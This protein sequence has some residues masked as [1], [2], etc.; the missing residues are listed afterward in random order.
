MMSSRCITP[1][2]GDRQPGPPLAEAA[3]H[4]Q[5]ETE[6]DRRPRRTACR[7]G[8]K[9]KYT[10]NAKST[11]LYSEKD[12]H[13]PENSLHKILVPRAPDFVGTSVYFND[14]Y[15]YFYGLLDDY[16]ERLPLHC[17]IKASLQD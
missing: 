11:S 7:P 9:I 6:T 10:H 16:S 3:G 13:G 12:Y 5:E 17:K 2:L 8:F 1:A 4:G 15:Y 14:Y